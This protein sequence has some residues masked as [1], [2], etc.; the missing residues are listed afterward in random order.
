MCVVCIH[1]SSKKEADTVGELIYTEI[2]ATETIKFNKLY[3][4]VS[5]GQ[6]TC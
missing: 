1:H 4:I 6:N 5:P 3:L 2:S